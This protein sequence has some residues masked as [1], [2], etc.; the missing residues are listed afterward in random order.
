MKDRKIDSRSWGFR[1]FPFGYPINWEYITNISMEMGLHWDEY[2]TCS[3]TKMRNDQ[4]ETGVRPVLDPR[5]K[6]IRK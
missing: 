6:K 3:E 2:E 1:Q 5:L 4:D